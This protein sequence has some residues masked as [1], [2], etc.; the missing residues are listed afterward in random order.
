[1]AQSPER[2]VTIQPA[3]VDASGRFTLSGLVPGRYRISVSGAGGPW[4]IA[5]AVA[6]GRDAMDVALDVRVGEDLGI[7]TI[8]MTDRSTT[9]TGTLT[10]SS[11]RA[12]TDY[13]IVAFPT[14]TAFWL[15]QAR[16]IQATRPATDGRYGFRG[17]PP[18]EYRIAVVPDVEPGQY[19]DPT[20]LRAALPAALSVTLADGQRMTQDLRVR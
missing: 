15:P 17:L 7:L 18:G 8:T 10:D 2:N 1:M 16:R 13:T 19:Y 12:T 6:A 4:T 20:W 11:N 14:D 5:S 3:A 9:L